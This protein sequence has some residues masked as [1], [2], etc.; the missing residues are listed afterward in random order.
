[1]IRQKTPYRMDTVSLRHLHYL[2]VGRGFRGRLDSHG[3]RHQRRLAILLCRLTFSYLE[4]RAVTVSRIEKEEG[5][6]APLRV[7]NNYTID[8]LD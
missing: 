1:M 5:M 7:G 6:F 4:P 2:A 3:F 8:Y